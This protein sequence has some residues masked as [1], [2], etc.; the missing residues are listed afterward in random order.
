MFHAEATDI[1]G[2]THEGKTSLN[3]GQKTLLISHQIPQRIDRHTGHSYAVSVRNNQ[4]Q[5]V[6]SLLHLTISRLKEPDRLLRTRLW[7]RP[8]MNYMEYEDFIRQFP[9]DPWGDETT[10][11][12]WEKTEPIRSHT[13]NTL[14]DSLINLNT[15]TTMPEGTYLLSWHCVDK[16]GDTIQRQDVIEL[17]SRQVD[18]P[19]FNSYLW[20]QLSR[21]QAE[22]GET[23]DLILSSAFPGSR[24]WVEIFNSKGLRQK[25]WHALG[26][27]TKSIPIPLTAADAGL[28]HVR[29]YGIMD[30]RFWEEEHH[31]A[32]VDK[33][34]TVLVEID[35][36]R[37]KVIPGEEEEWTLKL[38][39]GKGD[40]L[41]AEVLLSMY[42]ASLD[43]IAP[44]NWYFFPGGNEA[45]RTPWFGHASL[46]LQQGENQRAGF[47]VQ[48]E[49]RQ[50][51][52]DKV[53][54]F[55]W[56]F[57]HGR[58]YARGTKMSMTVQDGI[59]SARMGSG[60]PE[61]QD[62]LLSSYSP[63]IHKR[64][65]K[66]WSPFH[67]SISC[68][69]C[70]CDPRNLD[71]TAFFHPV[72]IPMK[73]ERYWYVFKAPEALTRWNL[74][75]FGHTSGLAVCVVPSTAGHCQDLCNTNLPRLLYEG[76]EIYLKAKV[77]NQGDQLLTAL[78]SLRFS[79]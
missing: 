49:I 50:Q 1:T 13:Y 51:E 6:S 12:R 67:P 14:T 5:P 22:T 31:V 66:C 38:S 62:D 43:A 37:N 72:L 70:T 54:W 21:D 7:P 16:Y 56:H 76:D 47:R 63:A 52:Y 60:R 57:W 55:G 35:R 74:M 27:A 17:F 42:D 61:S 53:N 59:Q 32:V 68:C 46:G 23:V 29:C 9:S 24:I 25:G 11:D 30:N 20:T 33:S 36:F 64:P 69:P 39:N 2:E 3:I 34:A 73:R 10:P 79:M 40:P 28:V 15:L 45:W 19:L 41:A 8:D 77:L 26:A 48:E 44:H 65:L 58:L 78:L 18:K 71:E 75:G 4:D